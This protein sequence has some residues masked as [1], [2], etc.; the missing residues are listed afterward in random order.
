MREQGREGSSFL[1]QQLGPTIEDVM[2]LINSDRDVI[3]SP[4]VFVCEDA[5]SSILS[6]VT[7]AHYVPHEQCPSTSW[8]PQREGPNPELNITEQPKQR[9]MRFRYQCEGRSTGSILGEKST[10]HNKTLPEIEIINCDGLE[11]IHV[12]V[13]LVWRDPPHRVHPHGLVGKDCHN[14]IC[15][16]TLNPQNGVAKHSFSNLGIQCVRKREIDSAVNER[17]KLN[18]DPYKAGKWRLHEE[19]DLNVVRLCFQASCTGPGFKY[20]IPPVLSDPIYDKK[21]TNT[22]ELKISRMNKEYGRCE[23]GEEVYILCDKVQKEDILVIFGEDKWEAR[24]DFSQAD[25]HRQIA[26][27]LKTP[28]YHDLHITEPACVRVFLQR[29]TDGIRSEGMPFV[30]MPRVKDPN[31]VHSKRKHRDCSQ[32]GDIGDP[33]PHGIEMKRRKVRPSY[34]DHLIPPYPDIN[35]PLMDSFNHN[36][37]YHDLPL[38]NPDEDAFHFLTEDPHFSD[39]LT[40]DPYFLDGYSN[41]FLPDQVNGVTAHLVGSSL[42][43]TDEEQPLPDCAF[44]DSGCRR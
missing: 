10:E 39:L 14:G 29:I 20:D 44:N 16:V 32:L 25:V 2:D 13:C 4:S 35:L 21:S 34:A 43:L 8:A 12:I 17:L 42:A 11:E 9:G 27:V 36:E 28:P 5:P 23:G 22:S 6:T 18:I 37:G 31:G 24:A 40:H 38:M 3:S 19:V 26:I 7:V 41:Q 33:D 15:E 30:Y 1:S